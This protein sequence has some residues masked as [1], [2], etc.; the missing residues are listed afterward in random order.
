MQSFNNDKTKQEYVQRI[1]QLTASSKP[2]WGKMN[3]QQMLNHLNDFFMMATEKKIK[4]DGAWVKAIAKLMG[5]IAKNRIIYS[6]RSFP[7]NLGN[8]PLPLSGNFDQEKYNLI[9]SIMQ[10]S[11]RDFSKES[12][13]IF[14]SMKPADWDNML[15]RQFNHH[16]SQF[17]V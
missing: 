14:G 12:L 17:G 16:L 5:G 7:K 11:E 10:Y 1:N 13:S 8:A 2:L 3:V 9:S 15:V 6:K 4:K